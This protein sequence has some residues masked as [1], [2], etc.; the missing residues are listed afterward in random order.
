MLDGIER[1]FSIDFAVQLA[2]DPESIV[3]MMGWT[4]LFGHES[5]T[6]PFEDA[7]AMAEVDWNDAVTQMNRHRDRF[8]EIV[9]HT[10]PSTRLKASGE[11]RG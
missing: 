8:I 10:D 9:R 3:E 4:A 5:N 2:R 6:R 7:R 11:L 1:Y